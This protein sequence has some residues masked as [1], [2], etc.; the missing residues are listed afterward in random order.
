MSFVVPTSEVGQCGLCDWHRCLITRPPAVSWYQLAISPWVKRCGA[1]A[2]STG[3]SG[4]V[5]MGGYTVFAYPQDVWKSS[6][7]G[8]EWRFRP[9][10]LCANLA[11]L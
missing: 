1:A 9:G 2:V 11:L 7:S 4:V 8:G 10:L 3:V 5:V 6:D